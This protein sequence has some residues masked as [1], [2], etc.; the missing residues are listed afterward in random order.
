MMPGN[1]PRRYA[2][3]L[4]L[5]LTLAGVV[6]LVIG[7][8]LTRRW[9][10]D[11]VERYLE[12]YAISIRPTDPWRFRAR[13]EQTRYESLTVVVEGRLLVFGGFDTPE[14]TV[15]ARVDEYDP[16]TDRWRRLGDMPVAVTHANAV[17]RDGEVW[18]VGGFVGAHPGP[19]TDQVWRYDPAA[20]SWRA[21]PSLPAPRGSGGLGLAADGSLHF[22]GGWLPDRYTDSPDHWRLAPGDSAWVA[23]APFPSPRG[24]F[25]TASHDGFIYAIGG[26]HTHDPY[27]V[28]VALVHRYDPA[29]DQWTQLASLPMPLSHIEPSTFVHEG[30]IHVA[31]GRSQPTGRPSVEEVMAYDIATDTWNFVATMPRGLLAPVA[32]PLGDELFLTAGGEG[33]S[34]PATLQSWSLPLTMPWRSAPPMPVALSEVAGGVI[35]GHLYLVGGEDGST[36]VLNLGTGE[37]LPARVASRRLVTAHH[38]AAEVYQ[39][40]LYL[41]G[42]IHASSLD[43]VQIYNPTRDEWRLGPPLPYA[44]G[45]AASAL[46]GDQIYLAGGIVGDTTTR[47]ALRLDLATGVWHAIAP[48]PR[49]RNHAAAATDGRQLF[50]F[51]GRGPGSGDSNVV[52]N[53]FDDVQ[54]YDPATDT[55]V[56]SG[57]GDEAPL[58]LPQARG[59]MGKAVYLNGEFYIFGGETLDGPGATPH[60]VY[61]RVD[62]YDPAANRWREGPP[63]PTAR[64]GIFPVA[65]GPWIW[66]AGGGVQAGASAAAVVEVLLAR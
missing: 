66:V 46:I 48:M 19:A 64:H 38:H 60:N 57:E 17:L 65:W 50:V 42:G 33:G 2:V 6:G 54:V 5:G 37:W 8:E 27:P 63:L 45:S 29:T 53:G 47:Q 20:D 40:E 58:P 1:V 30:R 59:G 51:G 21:G 18:I 55:W 36:L 22:F 62:I 52:A 16:A 34:N 11:A 13:A 15:T 12:R 23:A 41:L 24:H 10:W 31:G 44:T 39:D 3:L 56:A 32:M 26:C 7:I 35:N 49:A 25:G 9:P 4:L 28:D 14:L 43:L 61:P